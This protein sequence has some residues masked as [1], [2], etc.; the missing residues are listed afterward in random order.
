M[1]KFL[2]TAAAVLTVAV[3]TCLIGFA[4]SGGPGPR[5]RPWMYGLIVCFA[6]M[7]LAAA[8][9]AFVGAYHTIL[10]LFGWDGGPG[11]IRKNPNYVPGSDEPLPDDTPLH[12]PDAPNEL[13]RPAERPKA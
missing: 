10:A 5:G 9:M 1:P 12:V 3:L 7:G 2:R 11:I 13:V 6:I 8:Y 4:A